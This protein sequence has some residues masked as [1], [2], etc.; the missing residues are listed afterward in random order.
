MTRYILTGLFLV[1]CLT[2]L[3]QAQESDTLKVKIDSM[4]VIAS[5][6]DFKYRDLVEPTIDDIAA[7]GAPA[8][9][10]MIDRL[11]TID[12]RERVTLENIL[13]KI[14]DP[15][16]PLL[17]TALLTADS[18][19]LSRVATMLYYLPD[20][21]A[22]DNLIKVSDNDYYWARYNSVRALG[23]IG[24]MRAAETIRKALKDENELV[25]TMAAVAAGR[26][27]PVEFFDDLINVLD[28]EY[29]GVRFC[30]EEAL[31]QIECFDKIELL[32]VAL[33]KNTAYPGR[34]HLLTALISDSC[35]HDYESVRDLLTSPDPMV[36]STAMKLAFQADPDKFKSEFAIQ[37]DSTAT[38]I[39]QQTLREL[40]TD[41]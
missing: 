1:I 17:I 30:A 21:A 38:F 35:K 18:L 32:K 6:G 33:E 14:G 3:L 25:R 9:P 10:F 19:K 39:E 36:R 24:D 41:R 20:T 4:F 27:D 22:V 5:S 8:V 2:G 23:K 28:D 15:A 40:L 7:I 26:I 29:Y 34:G 16:K 37:V 13:K 11:G 12:A 31:S